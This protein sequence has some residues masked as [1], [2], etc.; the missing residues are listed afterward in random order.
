MGLAREWARLE[1]AVMYG[2]LG[3]AAEDIELIVSELVTNALR[4]GAD[5]LALAIDGH[6]STVRVAV[7][8][9]APGMP[10]IQDPL[11]DAERG[12]GLQIVA[13]LGFR[14][15]VVLGDRRKTVWADLPV[16]AGGGPTFDCTD[17]GSGDLLRT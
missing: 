13:A 1:L 14:W 16:P 4:A 7:T 8:D 2:R 12:R 9:D 3:A 5:Y 6:H 17:P 11:P 15:G 10:V